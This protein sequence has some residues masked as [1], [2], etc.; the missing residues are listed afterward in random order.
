[1]KRPSFRGGTVI[2]LAMTFSNPAAAEHLKTTIARHAG[3]IW[4]GWF[5]V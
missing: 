3:E 2:V 5:Q 1:M 4:G